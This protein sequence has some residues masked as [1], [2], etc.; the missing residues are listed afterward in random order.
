[1]P[2]LLVSGPLFILFLYCNETQ[3]AVVYTSAAQRERAGIGLIN[4]KW[5]SELV[6][7]KEQI[8]S[9]DFKLK[10]SFIFI[11]A[12]QKQYNVSQPFPCKAFE[13]AQ[14]GCILL[15]SGLSSSLQ[16]YGRTLLLFSRITKGKCSQIQ[17]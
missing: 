1:M 10:P 3:M 8:F 2:K 17:P 15:T 6:Q 9:N 13:L 7:R 5:V 16:A 11:R 4:C 12:R 14:W